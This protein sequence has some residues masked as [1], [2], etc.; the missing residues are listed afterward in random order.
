MPNNS[1]KILL[2]TT[3][4]SG[5]LISISSNS[6]FGAW[7][8]LEINLLS[9]IPM[10]MEKKNIYTT[11]ASLKY[12]IVQAGASSMLLFMVM[13]S[14]MEES[15][16]I[17]SDNLYTQMLMNTPL[18]LK[19]G[20]APMHWW[21]PGVMEGLNWNNCLILMTL[22][23]SAPLSL[24]SYQ[25]N[26][27]M[28]LEMIIVTSVMIGAIGGLNQTSL[29]KIMTY[30]SINHTGWMMSAMITGNDMWVTYFTIYSMLTLTVVSIVKTTKLSFV[31]QMAM[32]EKKNK[33]TKF[34]VFTSILSLG[35]LPPFLGFMPKWMVIQAMMTNEMKTTATMMVLMSVVTLYY[36]MRMTYSSLMMLHLETKWL[37]AQPINKTP[38]HIILLTSISITGLMM[39]EMIMNLD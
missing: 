39:S 30:S 25:I 3:L 12:F 10:M 5:I 26:N 24:I 16:L 2:L 6:W 8:G 29:R 9:F 22:Q 15:M 11:E 35:G 32:T 28:F 27:D 31:N 36:Y 13:M 19:G 17:N 34:L 37:I 33:L 20:V 21:F 7:M 14:A 18:L 23:K 38:K 1:T 4:T